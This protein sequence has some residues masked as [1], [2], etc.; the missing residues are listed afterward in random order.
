MAALAKSPPVLNGPTLDLLGIDG[1]FCDGFE[2][3]RLIEVG[4]AFKDLLA[5]QITCTVESRDFMPGSK[6]TD[7]IG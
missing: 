4:N 6:Q 7:E 3:R 1:T 2:T 5:G